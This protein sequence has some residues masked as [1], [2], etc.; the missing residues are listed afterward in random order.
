MKYKLG[1]YTINDLNPNCDQIFKT[2][3]IK[4]FLTKTVIVIV[5]PPKVMAIAYLYA[6]IFIF[7]TDIYTRIFTSDHVMILLELY[8][9]KGK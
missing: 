5:R 2:A 4:F 6:I 7:Q 9:S 1:K 8:S 3:Q